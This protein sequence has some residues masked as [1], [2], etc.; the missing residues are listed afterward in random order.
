[1]NA[2]RSRRGYR[3]GVYPGSF[4]PPTIAHV[5]IAEAAV[6]AAALDHLDFAI[7]RAPL[8]KD[9]TNQ[10]SL[11][12]RLGALERLA[13]TRPPL[14]VVV[15]DHRL[16][17]DIAADYDVVVMGADK[18][19]QVRDA[20]WYDSADARDAALRRLPRVLVAP[21]PGFEVVGA[22]RLEL[23]VDFGHVSS[24]AARTGSH[25]LIVP[26]ARRRLIVDGNNVIGSRPDGWWRDRAGAARRLITSLEALAA[27][28]G[29]RISVVLDGRPLADV[30]E[31]VHNGVLVAY[32]TRA[33]RDAAD[34]R[35]VAEVARDREPASLVV[36]TSDRGLADR[37]RALGATVEAAGSLL[38]QLD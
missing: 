27:R 18:W 13:S 23:P 30:P 14:G 19:A 25:H 7:S 34:D 5:A 36:V 38:A 11:E 17:T 12:T 26:E 8:G 1:M 33:G 31:G 24:T 21:R 6:R 10:R 35:I 9:A 2:D 4:D 29:D 20:A 3:R 37:V 22:E 16:I 32:A 28:S 15:T